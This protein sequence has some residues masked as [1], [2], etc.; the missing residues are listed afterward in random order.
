MIKKLL[1]FLSLLLLLGA[2]SQN[3]GKNISEKQK[4]ITIKGKIQKGSSLYANLIE[5]NISPPEA[6]NA[7]NALNKIYNLFY[8]Q[9]DDSFFITIDSLNNIHSLKFYHNSKN[10]YMVEKDSLDNFFSHRIIPEMKKKDKVEHEEGFWV[11]LWHDIFSKS[12]A[13][14]SRKYKK[15]MNRFKLIKGKI[16]Y[17][18][19]L[20]SLLLQIDADYRN[21]Y[22]ITNSLNKKFNL[23]LVQP[24]DSLNVYLDSLNHVQILEYFPNNYEM[25]IVQ[26]DSV[27]SYQTEK[28]EIQL[29]KKIA[30]FSTTIKTSLWESFFKDGLEPRLIMDYTNIFQWDIDFFIDP[31]KND[32]CS[33]VYEVFTNNGN[34]LRYGNILAAS[35]K[36]KKFDLTAYYFNPNKKISGFYDSKGKSF[37]KAFLRSPLNYSFISSYFGRRI[38][39][40]TRKNWLHNGVDYAAKRGTPVQVSA[41]GVVI[42]RGWKGG[43]PTPRG[44]IGGYGNTIM[45]R[46]PNGYQTLYGHLSYFARGVYLNSHIEQ[47]DIIGYVGS[48]GWSTGPHLHYTI[49]YHKRPINPLRLNNVAGPP[50]PKK[51]MDKFKKRVAEM[52][53]YLNNLYSLTIKT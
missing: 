20:Y 45:V 46:H 24:D 21:A 39:P 48:T 22:K 38:H 52:N 32:T 8:A 36:G 28:Y 31:R 10:K 17:G 29:E 50:V 41:S 40:I 35:Y 25:Y 49:Y 23:H 26:R 6:Y 47:G 19:S 16:D 5:N 34:I 4:F 33:F 15:S 14:D 9:P 11:K 44:N 13:Q 1:I 51:Y 7:T 53:N 37:Q 3:Q 27:G 18:S 12:E 2:C 43:H 30:T 42:Y